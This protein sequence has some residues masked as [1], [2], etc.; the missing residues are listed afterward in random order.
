LA[1]SASL[2]MLESGI[3]ARCRKR[4]MRADQSTPHQPTPRSALFPSR[5]SSPS[6]AASDVIRGA[7]AQ[8]ILTDVPSTLPLAVATRITVGSTF[9]FNFT[10]ARCTNLPS[11]ALSATVQWTSAATADSLP[12]CKNVTF[13]TGADCT[14]I[15]AS[16]VAKPASPTTYTSFAG[17]PYPYPRSA[18]CFIGTPFLASQ[19]LQHHVTDGMAGALPPPELLHSLPHAP[20]ATSPLSLTL[21]TPSPPL[22]ALPTPSHLSL[23]GFIP[24]APDGD[25]PWWP[26]EVPARVVVT[27]KLTVGAYKVAFDPSSRCASL[28]TGTAPAGVSTAASVQWNVPCT[29]VSFFPGSSCNGSVQQ[30]MYS[31]SSNTAT[32][33]SSQAVVSV[34]CGFCTPLDA[35]RPLMPF[36]P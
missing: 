5:S 9:A 22:A 14:G 6:P 30:H 24:V 28:P 26:T 21:S 29:R 36:A 1:L 11:T 35:F 20:R 10:A 8:D 34:V 2:D 13:L 19:E 15:F 27:T 18:L 4:G 31:Y 23:H 32:I 16:S 12:A 33:T 25:A 3:R 7:S 17:L